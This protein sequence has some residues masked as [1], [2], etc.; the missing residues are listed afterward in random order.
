LNKKQLI[1][2]GVIDI[3]KYASQFVF[4]SIAL[5]QPNAKYWLRI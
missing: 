2:G 5:M 3:N 1:L 4:I